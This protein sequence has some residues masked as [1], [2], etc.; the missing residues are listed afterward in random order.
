MPVDEHEKQGDDYFL[1]KCA[2][3]SPLPN[4]HKVRLLYKHK[5]LDEAIFPDLE[6]ALD[7]RSFQKVG[8]WDLLTMVAAGGTISLT[9]PRFHNASSYD[10][11]TIKLTFMACERNLVD[12][13][14]GIVFSKEGNVTYGRPP[15]ITTLKINQRM[16]SSESQLKG[17]DII[18]PGT[19]LNLSLPSP[20]YAI[21]NLK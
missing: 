5:Q 18:S 9:G 10:W 20:G 12:A 14:M 13:L 3:Y 16:M 4:G 11:K 21:D 6:T 1:G 15:S 8:F 2:W 7:E 19:N 17:L